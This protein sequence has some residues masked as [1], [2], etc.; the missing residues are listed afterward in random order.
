MTVCGVG[1]NVAVLAELV[2]DVLISTFVVADCDGFFDSDA[3]TPFL[4]RPRH[5]DDQQFIYG[6]CLLCIL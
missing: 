6:A 4:P 1:S 5:I 3:I 2:C